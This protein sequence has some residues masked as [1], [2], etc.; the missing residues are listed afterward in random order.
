[1]RPLPTCLR[2]STGIGEFK[3]HPGAYRTGS[4]P[5][6]RRWSQ[7]QPAGKG[8]SR[9][10]IPTFTRGVEN[11]L[12]PIDE[13]GFAPWIT[14]AASWLLRPVSAANEKRSPSSRIPTPFEDW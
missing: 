10:H 5:R 2:S 14:P 12:F 7:R 9:L 13:V 8:S 4:V 1:M 3:P 6:C 11:D